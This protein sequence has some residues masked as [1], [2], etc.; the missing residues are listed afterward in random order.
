MRGENFTFFVKD[1]QQA[2]LFRQLSE[3]GE[4]GVTVEREAAVVSAGGLQ[5]DR[6]DLGLGGENLFH[7]AEVWR[8]DDHQIKHRLREA[9]QIAS[10]REP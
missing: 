5:N 2:V 1:Q 6:R 8:Q 4:K 10:E 3:C 7:R 9:E